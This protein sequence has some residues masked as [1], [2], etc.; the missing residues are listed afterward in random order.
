MSLSI[1]RDSENITKATLPI[2]D[3]ESRK[4]WEIKARKHM[5]KKSKQ[6][7]KTPKLDSSQGIGGHS[8]VFEDQFKLRSA[9]RPRLIMITYR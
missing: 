2:S 8:N 9:N 6:T 3:E 5:N 1:A 7:N 4:Y